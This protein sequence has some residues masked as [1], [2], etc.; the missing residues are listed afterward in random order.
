LIFAGSGGG[1]SVVLSK[2]EDE[3]RIRKSRR[4]CEF[5]REE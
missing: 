5:G 4:N 2:S 1:E 3:E